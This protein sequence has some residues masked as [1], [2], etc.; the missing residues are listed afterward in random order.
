MHT[1]QTERE[2]FRNIIRNARVRDLF[3]RRAQVHS[4]LYSHRCYKLT[5]DKVYRAVYAD[6]T[7]VIVQCRHQVVYVAVR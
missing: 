1:A 6:N 5:V 2:G 7:A 4:R 3:S